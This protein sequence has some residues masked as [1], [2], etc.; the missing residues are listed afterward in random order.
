MKLVQ[1]V[2]LTE[3]H[4]VHKLQEPLLN[5]QC[6]ILYLQ[7]P[8]LNCSVFYG[9]MHHPLPLCASA[10]C[11]FHTVRHA[12]SRYLETLQAVCASIT[13]MA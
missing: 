4:H 3:D 12:V 9:A 10:T 7:C 11:Q 6:L 13:A 2:E 1:Q 8:S 5:L